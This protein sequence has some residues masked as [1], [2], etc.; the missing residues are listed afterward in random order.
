MTGC[1]GTVGHILHQYCGS[2]GES[3]FLGPI[4]LQSHFVQ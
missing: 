1:G 4:S 2:N 3:V